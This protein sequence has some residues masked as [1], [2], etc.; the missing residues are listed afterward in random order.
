MR[1]P[2]RLLLRPRSCVPKRVGE[3][4]C[5]PPKCARCSLCPR[6]LPNMQI[7][8][9]RLL[10]NF[11][12]PARSFSPLANARAAQ[13]KKAPHT[14][15]KHTHTASTQVAL[16][17]RSEPEAVLCLL[18]AYQNRIAGSKMKMASR[19]CL[20]LADPFWKK[21]TCKNTHRGI[22]NGRE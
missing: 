3:C 9:V 8:V 13:P 21:G 22:V 19:F 20:A 18:C 4:A 1:A 11:D 14:F 17:L 6:A 5:A 7:T 2:T 10:G 16:C 12:S 15:I